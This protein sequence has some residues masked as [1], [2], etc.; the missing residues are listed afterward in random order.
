MMNPLEVMNALQQ[1]APFQM[2]DKVLQLEPGK[3]AIGLKL[4]SANE[5]CLNGHFPGMP[6][7]P[8]TMIIESAAQLCAITI[9]N[10][11]DTIKAIVEINNFKIIHPIVPGDAMQIYCSVS[12]D[13]GNALQILDV[14]IE[15]N[16]IVC[17]KGKLSFMS[18]PKEKIYK[19][20]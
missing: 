9:N 19:E 17:A 13:S 12:E 2:I 18:I 8:G 10:N 16:S 14:R 7:M 1:K 15:V 3:S 4:V 6:I 11:D 5:P 20:K